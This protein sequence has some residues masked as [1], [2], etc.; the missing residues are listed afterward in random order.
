MDTPENRE[1]VDFSPSVGRVHVSA[2]LNESGNVLVHVRG[3]GE[4]RASSRTLWRALAGLAEEAREDGV[5]DEGVHRRAGGDGDDADE[6]AWEV[7][8]RDAEYKNTH[9]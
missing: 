4:W 8:R 5:I 7:R 3:E 2:T 1:A 9:R 6:E